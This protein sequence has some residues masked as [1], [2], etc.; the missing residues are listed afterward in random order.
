MMKGTNDNPI[1]LDSETE[2]TPIEV[3]KEEARNKMLIENAIL[4]KNP[5]ELSMAAIQTK[6]KGD[7][8]HKKLT[9]NRAII[10]YF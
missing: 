7:L 8:N 9:L 1:D 2:G 6:I 3:K 5:L 4:T 10:R